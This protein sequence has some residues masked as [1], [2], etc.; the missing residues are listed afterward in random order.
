SKNENNLDEAVQDFISDSNSR[1]CDIMRKNAFRM[2]TTLALAV[3]TDNVV[4][5]YNIGDS[6]IYKFQDGTLS[7]ISED[8]TVAEQKIKMGLLTKEEAR[9]DKSKHVLTRCLGIFEDEMILTPNIITPFNVNKEC[10][11]MICSDGLTD[12]LTDKDIENIF[13][14]NQ[15]TSQTT[16]ILVNNALKNGGR[17]NVTCILIDFL[18]E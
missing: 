5:A 18:G 8:H 4:K 17:D 14:E 12:M 1:L 3:I 10:R 16:N 6:R 11:L 7:Q 15:N 2:G 9:H 13:K